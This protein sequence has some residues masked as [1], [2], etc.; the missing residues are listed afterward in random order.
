MSDIATIANRA[1]TT[2]RTIYDYNPDRLPFQL[3]PQVGKGLGTAQT[4]SDTFGL[5]WVVPT[6]EEVQNEALTRYKDVLGGIR[7]KVA[8]T[9]ESAISVTESAS[10][11]LKSI[12]WLI[13]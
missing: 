3:P 8:P 10:T 11:V 2:I 5:G 1:N 13:G 9:L 6:A 7:R 4:V 12:E